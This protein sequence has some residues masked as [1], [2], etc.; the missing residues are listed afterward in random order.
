MRAAIYLRISLDKSGDE[1]GVTR[2]REDCLRIA[3]MRGVEVVEVLSENDTSAAGKAKR[4]MFEQMM[5]LLES[6]E[7]DTIIAWSFDRLTR[8]R[9]DTLRLLELGQ[10][11]ELLIILARG[12]DIDMSTPM[13]RMIAGQMAEWARFEID[14]KSDRHQSANL[15]KAKLGKPHGSRRPFGYMD[16]MRT[17]HPGESS[18]LR[19]MG[20]RLVSGAS[21]RELT[22]W[23]NGEGYVTAEGKRFYPITV[24]NLLQ[25]ARY[26]GLRSYKGEIVGRG[27]WE[28]VFTDDEW[29]AIQYTIRQR[30]DSAGSHPVAKKYM[31][32]GLL[33]CGKCGGFLNGE[34]KRDPAS[35]NGPT[36]DLRRVYVCRV[37]GDTQRQGGCGGVTRNADALEHFI[38]EL[39]CFRLDSDSLSSLLTPTEEAGQLASLLA[40]REAS[41]ARKNALLDDYVDGTLG[42]PE[43]SRAK[44]RVEARL[45]AIDAQLDEIRRSR[46]SVSLKAGETVRQAWMSRSD[47]W[48]RELIGTLVESI[49]VNV[50]KS[51]PFYNVDGK[52][53]RFD[54]NLIDVVWKV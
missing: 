43:Y 26:G 18:I 34:T 12:S 54:P 41:A 36:R 40:E 38:R 49:T 24:R 1:L 13:G 17:L 20:K 53:M 27:D 31:L 22:Y 48:R 46:I 39:V 52:R 42:K 10:E 23:L 35:K 4:P 16:D 11:K 5:S 14:V 21:Y 6:G 15:Q 32:T 9:R 47:S 37:H 7:I 44:N 25:K 3:E 33:R 50:G 29:D 30:R 51:K 19:E 2:Q 45:R 28:P 8:N